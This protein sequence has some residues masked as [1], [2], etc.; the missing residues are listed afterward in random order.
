MSIMC[1][2]II[3]NIRCIY[4]WM[5]SN[6]HVAVYP[7]IK[8]KKHRVNQFE[9]HPERWYDYCLYNNVGAN[10][11]DNLS[12]VVVD[13]MLA[14]K[15]LKAD[16]ETRKTYFLNTIGS[17][18]FSS[19]QNAVIWGSG[20]GNSVGT[21]TQS[22]IGRILHRRIFRRLDI[23]AVRGPLTRQKLI[24]YRH[25]CPEI[26]GDPA[27]LMPLIYRPASFEKKHDI[28]VIPQFLAEKEI[29]EKYPQY[30]MLSMNTDDYK[31]V[32]DMICSSKKVITSSLHGIILAQAY[33][34][35]AV[36]FKTLP[37]TFKFEDYYAS[38]GRYNV[39]FSESLEDALEMEPLPLPDLSKLQQ[40]L[41]ESFPYDLWEK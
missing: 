21:D 34:V 36:Y 41:M 19:F 2:K 28:L 23:R 11:G 12:F 15:G 35:P 38:T 7:D 22:L 37:K 27:I 39:H 13:W 3:R 24:R 25:R 18:V 20:I 1:N 30:P 26:Y 40:G 29:R 6:Q 16:Q 32:I 8:A 10:L 4:Y 33:G 14:K 31:Q 17:N 9:Y 5:R